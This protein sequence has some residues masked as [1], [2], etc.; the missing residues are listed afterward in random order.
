[1]AGRELRERIGRQIALAERGEHVIF[2]EVGEG[3]G[4][5]SHAPY[6]TS[7]NRAPP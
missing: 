1:M 5:R 4:W 7:F 2:A 3:S 6:H